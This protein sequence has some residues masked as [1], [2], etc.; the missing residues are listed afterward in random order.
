M[1]ELRRN[2]R[3]IERQHVNEHSCSHFSPCFDH[4]CP[5]QNDHGTSQIDEDIGT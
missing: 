3:W 1:A 2:Q 5:T 4:T